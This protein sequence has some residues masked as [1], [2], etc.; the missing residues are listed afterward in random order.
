[1]A[2]FGVV[3]A[4]VIGGAVGALARWGAVT[5]FV[6]QESL[7]VL[8]LNVAGSLVL[9]A[10]IGQRERL[11]ELT[12]SGIGPGFCGGLTT[13]STFAVD[14]AQRL[15]DGMILSGFG[16]ALATPAAAV[17]AAG[18]GYQSSR[19][20]GPVLLNRRGGRRSLR[21]GGPARRSRRGGTRRRSSR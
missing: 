7:V 9:G 2:R 1:M 6:D 13:F 15:D 5:A 12:F 14:V 3:L 11:S 4:V 20:L 19:R 17:V 16:N 21:P 18:L 8:A 10:V